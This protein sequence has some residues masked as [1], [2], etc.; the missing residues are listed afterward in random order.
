MFVSLSIPNLVEPDDKLVLCDDLYDEEVDEV[1]LWNL[2]FTVMAMY[3]SEDCIFGER[4]K[5]SNW[6]FQGRWKLNVDDGGEFV[7]GHKMWAANE[8]FVSI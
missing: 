1:L 5:N 3:E 4:K 6:H 7:V 8:N 2:D